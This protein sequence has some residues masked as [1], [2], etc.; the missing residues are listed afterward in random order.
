MVNVRSKINYFVN[1]S[2]N[3]PVNSFFYIEILIMKIIPLF[4]ITHDWNIS[5]KKGA[6]YWVRKF[7]FSEFIFSK[8]PYYFNP[9]VVI[10]IF[11]LLIFALI[12]KIF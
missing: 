12:F 4:I 3:F 11:L 6:S 8:I 1:I 5:S 10:I 9:T 7:I 2:K